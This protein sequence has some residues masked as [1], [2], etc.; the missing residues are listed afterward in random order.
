MHQRGI[1]ELL[2]LLAGLA[3]IV[4]IASGTYYVAGLNY[5][6]PNPPIPTPYAQQATTTPDPTTDWK[7][8]TNTRYGIS[9]KYP[10]EWKLA[11]DNYLNNIQDYI[12][13]SIYETTRDSYRLELY[14]DFIGGF[15]EG[16]EKSKN[17]IVQFNNGIKGE[18]TECSSGIAVNFQ[19]DGNNL[20]LI[21][22][23][24]D[25]NRNIFNQILSTFKF[26]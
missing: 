13:F 10:R 20:W 26:Q 15:C 11:T 8:Y 7:T 5:K 23:M 9:I 6:Q 16:D 19:K 14:K 18:K 3:V 25:K 21:T 17:T 24:S 12:I 1:S 4:V 22:V 2:V